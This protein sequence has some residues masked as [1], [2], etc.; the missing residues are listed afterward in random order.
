[1]ENNRSENRLG[2]KS[3]QSHKHNVKTV[4]GYRWESISVIYPQNCVGA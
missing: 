3:G 2:R 1:M 4:L